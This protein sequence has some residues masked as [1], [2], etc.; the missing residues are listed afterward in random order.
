MGQAADTAQQERELTRQALEERVE[1]F[2]QRVRDELDWRARLRRNRVRLLVAGLAAAGAVALVA[3]IRSRRTSEREE[4]PATLDDVT[5]ELHEIRKELERRR[6]ESPL[7]QKLL[8][9]GAAT[10]ASAGGAAMARRMVSQGAGAQ[11]GVGAARA[12]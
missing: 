5:R 11:E 12:G 2:E 1:R 9:R 8:I 4:L 6:G 7:W 3:V 10:A